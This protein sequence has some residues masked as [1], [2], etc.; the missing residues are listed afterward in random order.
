MKAKHEFIFFSLSPTGVGISGGDRIFIELARE[1]SKNISITIYTTQEGV[2]MCKR[3]KLKG[4][5]LKIKNLVVKLPSKFLFKY[6]YK[7]YLGIKLG[8]SLQ[9]SNHKLPITNLYSS[10][11][12]WMD[13]LPCVILKIRFPKLK[14]IASWYQTAPNPLKGFTESNREK[15]YRTSSFYYWLM[16][17][18]IKPLI[19]KYADF[20]IVNN[21]EERKQFPEMSTK[22]KVIVLLGAVRLD[23]IKKFLSTN[24]HLLSTK[25]YD[26]VFQGR[27]HPQKGVLELIDIWK[28]VVDKIPNAKLA[29]IG[30]GPLMDK[31]KSQI[32]NYKLQNNV[33]LF[34]YVFDGPEKYKI[35][36]QSKI[37]VHPA[38]YDSGGMA[39]A[40]AMAFGL[41]AVGF[42]LK[43]YKSYYPEGMLKAEIGQYK[44]LSGYIIKL[45][46]NEELRNNLG[47][48][49][50]EMVYNN[51]S[52][53]RRAKNLHIMLFK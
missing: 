1:W 20:V 23:E 50:K 28:K 24:H 45:L 6:L 33:K 26:A 48:K 11:E 40:E 46:N 5:H 22:N 39:S 43:A 42:N 31:V 21:E 32:I 15:K 13:S 18:P 2:E 44:T 19:K 37:V 41:P 27:F 51:L 36:S 12:F 30:D 35:F 4:L 14:W 3:Q 25:R 38:L 34:G 9:I 7:I 16:Q 29:M 52:W 10:S 8:F 49:A 47:D 53:K 17:L